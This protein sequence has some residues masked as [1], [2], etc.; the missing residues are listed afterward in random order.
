MDKLAAEFNRTNSGNTLTATQLDHESFKSSIRDDFRLGNTA[1]VYSYW[2]GERVQS[3]VEQLSPVDDVLPQAEMKKLFG[4]AIVKSA[5]TYN[6][7]TYLVPLTQH[8]V[9]FF[10]NKKIFAQHGLTPPK[11]WNEFIRISEK[12]KATGVIPLALGSKSRWPAQFWFDYLLLRTATLEYRHKLLSGRA[13]FNDPE[14]VRV[15]S[16]W[17]DLIKRG[18]FN[19]N[20][21]DIEF[22]SGAAMMVRRGEAAMTL[23]G[24]WLI[25]Y[26]NSPEINWHEDSEYGFFP[27]PIIDPQIPLVAL[28]PIDGL[29]VPKQ[30]KNAA[31]AKAVVKYFAGSAAQKI[32]SQGS[33]AIA[34][35]LEVGHENYSPLKLAV[36]DEILR[37]RAWAFNYDLATL[38]VRAEVG[39]NLFA[40]FLEF[41]DHYKI[42][43]DKAEIRMKSPAGL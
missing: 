5:C 21:N 10:F 9:G 38:P 23:M 2:A 19:K 27:F 25:G 16:M 24:T 39:L 6:G 31:G 30:A 29:V 28:G 32:M 42:L 7:R 43:L 34:P 15:F 17:R 12:L 1:D 36:Q 18:L 33:G 8:Y 4:A 35:N 3:I 11:D 22:D 14:V 37:S 26:Y 13:S 41:P 40:E 20:T